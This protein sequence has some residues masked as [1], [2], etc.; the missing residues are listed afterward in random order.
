[1]AEPPSPPLPP[2]PD[3]PLVRVCCV[4]CWEWFAGDAKHNCPGPRPDPERLNGVIAHCGW[5]EKAGAVCSGELVVVGFVETNSGPGG[6]I[7]A[8][9]PCVEESRLLPLDEHPP[10]SWGGVRYRPRERER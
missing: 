8:C 5:C 9:P 7:W 2:P 10:D 4:I 1:M 6:W 3:P